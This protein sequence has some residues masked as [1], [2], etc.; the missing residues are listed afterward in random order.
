MVAARPFASRAA[1]IERSDAVC[2]SLQRRDW[3]QAFAAHPRIGGRTGDRWAAREQAGARAASPDVLARLA[4]RN[5]EYEA[6]FGHM[7]IVCATGRSADEMLTLLEARLDNEP[8]A[9]LEIAADEQ[10]KITRLRL[11]KLLDE[12]EAGSHEHD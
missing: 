5:R 11:E 9:E 10:R 3:L 12:P 6:R 2:R 7:F 1:L 4:D 8:D